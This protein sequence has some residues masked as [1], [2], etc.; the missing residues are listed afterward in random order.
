MTHSLIVEF[1]ALHRREAF[2]DLPELSDAAFH[3][4]KYAA[5]ALTVPSPRRVLPE[6][7]ALCSLVPYV[8]R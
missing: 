4:A 3:E 6:P 2:Q 1:P 7:L 5:G 8:R